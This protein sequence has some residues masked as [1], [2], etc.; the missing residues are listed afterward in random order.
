MAT[1]VSVRLQ[2]SES[3]AGL[4]RLGPS[5]SGAAGTC[6]EVRHAGIHVMLCSAPALTCMWRRVGP[7]SLVACTRNADG[8]GLAAAHS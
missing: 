8:E 3:G 1:H 5:A 4:L 6:V 2:P 7:H